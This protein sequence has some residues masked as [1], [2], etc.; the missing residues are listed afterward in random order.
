MGTR[1]AHV[2][3]QA[4]PLSAS[5]EEYLEAILRLGEGGRAVP[6]M[7]LARHLAVRPASITSMLRRLSRLGLIVYRR[8]QDIVLTEEGRRQAQRL[9]RRHRL[10]ER[11]L[12]DFL[13]LPLD[14]A[15]AE[16]C[17]FEHVVSPDLEGRISGALGGPQTCPHGH[18]INPA[19][20]DRTRS[21]LEAPLNRRLTIARLEDETPEVIRYLAERKL[22]PGA[23]VAVRQRRAAAGTVVLE[24][25]GETHTLGVAL[26]GTI[27]VQVRGRES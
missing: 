11:L 22:L 9:I 27:R 15:H 3:T 12:T 2:T 8:Y 21:L 14:Q 17:R 10:A 26:A 24:S 13:G 25:G 6:P 4:P 19:G 5:V 18:P 7:A 1:E 16:A 20:R 23:E